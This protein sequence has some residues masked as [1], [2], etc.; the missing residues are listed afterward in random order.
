[1]KPQTC[2]ACGFEVA[3]MRQHS[4]ATVFKCMCGQSHFKLPKRRA[5][6]SD[7][8]IYGGVLTAPESRAQ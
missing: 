7:A 8:K 1:M 2:P 4:C 3:D 6:L 5:K